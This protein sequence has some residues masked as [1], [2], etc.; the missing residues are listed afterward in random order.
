[1]FVVPPEVACTVNDQLPT[2]V[3]VPVIVPLTAS[4]AHEGSGVLG[5]TVTVADAAAYSVMVGCGETYVDAKGERHQYE[6]LFIP[7]P[8]ETK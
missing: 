1:M 2:A 6:C 7:Q 8:A 4:V 3:G 5:S